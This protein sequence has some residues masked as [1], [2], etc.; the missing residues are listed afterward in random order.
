MMLILHLIY[1]FQNRQQLHLDYIKEM[2]DILEI[3]FLKNII[4]VMVEY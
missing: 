4:I 3:I 1:K 2:K